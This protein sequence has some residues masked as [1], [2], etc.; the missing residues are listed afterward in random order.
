MYACQGDLIDWQD[1][2]APA[3]GPVAAWPKGCPGP[4]ATRTR[5]GPAGR[6]GGADPA[7]DFSFRFSNGLHEVDVFFGLYSCT[8]QGFNRPGIAK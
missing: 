8:F 5:A 3:R 6:A 4:D 7:I 2:H 1:L